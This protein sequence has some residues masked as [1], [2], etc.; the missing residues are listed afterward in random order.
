VLI[1][2]RLGMQ[3]SVASARRPASGVVLRLHL[4]VDVAL[5]LGIH[6]N[7]VRSGTLPAKR[8]P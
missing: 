8:D 5:V 1:Y 7:D 4:N 3:A 6:R 2:P